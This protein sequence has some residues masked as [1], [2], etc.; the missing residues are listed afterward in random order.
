MK[1]YIDSDFKCHTSND[2]TMREVE[3]D[4]FNSKC[5][6]FIEGF[7][8]VPS[9]ESW[10]RS[11]GVV[12]QGEMITPW[13]DYNLLAAYQEAY[14]EAKAESAAQIADMKNALEVELGVMSIPDEEVTV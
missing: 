14:D 10:T 1:I 8:Y 2:G 12:F 11:D 4:F 3:T 5:T 9:G 6:T 13:K 7:Y